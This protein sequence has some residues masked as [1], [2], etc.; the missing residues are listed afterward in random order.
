MCMWLFK[1]EHFNGSKGIVSPEPTAKLA[2]WLK[3]IP[4]LKHILG[5]LAPNP[6]SYQHNFWGC[7]I[8]WLTSFLWTPTVFKVLRSRTIVKYLL[9]I[10]NTSYFGVSFPGNLLRMSYYFFL[11]LIRTR[12]NEVRVMVLIQSSSSFILFQ[13]TI[14]QMYHDTHKDGSL[15][16]L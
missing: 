14:L 8:S 11:P 4:I 5:C 13:P 2:L 3:T 10:D 6:H 15:Q 7:N 9:G 16:N 12:S 1:V